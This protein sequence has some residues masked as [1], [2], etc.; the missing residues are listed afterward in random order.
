VNLEE[1]VRIA[2]QQEKEEQQQ[3]F[4]RSATPHLSGVFDENS[5]NFKLESG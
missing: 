5:I 1:R 4:M 3:E 2:L